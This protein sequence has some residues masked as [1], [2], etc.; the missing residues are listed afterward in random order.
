[1]FRN[2]V[3]LL[4]TY[5]LLMPPGVCMCGSESGGGKSCLSDCRCGQSCSGSGCGGG[6]LHCDCC[7]GNHGMPTDDRCPPSCP[8]QKNADHSKWTDSGPAVTVATVASPPLSFYVDGSA[9]QR[10]QALAFHWQPPAQP[11]Y[12]TLCTLVI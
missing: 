9:G 8:A 2:V 1:M 7:G 10:I 4:V 12:I 3:L 6:G 11:L 5:P